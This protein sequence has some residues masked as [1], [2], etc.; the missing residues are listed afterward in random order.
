M[1]WR[2]CSL[3]LSHWCVWCTCYVDSLVLDCSISSANALEI[4]QSCTKPLMCVWC[5]CYVDG[6]VLDC[7]IS[8]ANALEIL[9]SCTKPLMCV[10]CTCYVDGLVLDCSISIANTLEILQSCTKPSMCVSCCIFHYSWYNVYL[11][12]TLCLFDVVFVATLCWSSYSSCWH[13][14][15]RITRSASRIRWG[16]ISK[17]CNN[18]SSN[19]VNSSSTLTNRRP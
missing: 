4:L 9:Q 3:A 1:H 14:R 18:R 8:I 10:W 6:L 16:N 7:S 15:M 17:N 2:Y 13:H 19:D 12:T 11:F 5:T